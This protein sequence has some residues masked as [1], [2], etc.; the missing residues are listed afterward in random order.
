MIYW[1]QLIC[2]HWKGWIE[3]KTCINRTLLYGAIAGACAE[4]ATYLFEVLRR[5]LQMQ[6][7]STKLS[8]L[9]T[10]FETV[11]QGGVPALFC[12]L[13]WFCVAM[14]IGPSLC[15]ISLNSW[16]SG[17]CNISYYFI[18]DPSISIYIYWLIFTWM[19]LWFLCSLF[20]SKEWSLGNIS[21]I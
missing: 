6:F 18:P 19:T 1:N 8:S 4:A 14:I 11:E 2:N 16:M 9:A 13:A 10:F 7:Q 17:L 15:A 5:Q 12:L 3:S 21:L 20:I